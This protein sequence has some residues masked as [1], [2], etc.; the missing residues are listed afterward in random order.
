MHGKAIS[1]LALAVVLISSVTVVTFAQEDLFSARVLAKGKKSNILI[2]VA[3]SAKSTQS[4]HEIEIKFTQGKPIVA[5]ARGWD[6]QRSGDTMTFTAT[7]SDLGPGGRVI[8]IIK[9]SDAA[10]SAFQWSAMAS[11]GKELQKGDVNKIRIREAPKDTGSILPPVT[12]PEV[13]VDKTKA[14]Y[15]DQLKVNGRGYTVNSAVVI[16]IDQQEVGRSTTDAT[17]TFSSVI[18][19]PNNIGAGLHLIRAVDG[20]NKSSVI[21]ILI[22]APAGA[23]P[24]LQGGTLVVRTDR[25][26]YSPGDVIKMTGSAVLDTP[27]SLQITDPK[28]GIICGANPQ[29]NNKTLLWDATCVIPGNA[30]AGRYVINAAQIIHKTTAVFTVRSTSTTGPGGTITDGDPTEDPGTLRI[31]FD[32]EKYKVGDTA[33]VTITG[34]RPKSLLDVIVDGPG[35]HLAADRKTMDDAGSVTFPVALTGSAAIGVWKVTGKQMDSDQKKQFIVRKSFTVE[36]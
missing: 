14:F 33:Q 36:P 31:S 19:L 6:S 7:R 12:V 4:V 18:L 3:S 16:Y 26:E 25:E 10:S 13:N 21:Q 30:I 34:A 8:L 20:S 23:L 2:L 15:G 27:V 35:A 32:K 29:V 5:I 17:G 11:N 28:G 9:V 1:A 22:E 24:P